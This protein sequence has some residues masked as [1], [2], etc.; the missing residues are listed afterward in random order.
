[1]F[2]MFFE[3]HLYYKNILHKYVPKNLYNFCVNKIF[4]IQ[5]LNF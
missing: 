3:I 5:S 4:D 1:M 2:F